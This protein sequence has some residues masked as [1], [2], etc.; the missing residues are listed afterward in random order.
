MIKVNEISWSDEV[1]DVGCTNG[2]YQPATLV[3]SDGTRMPIEVCRCG[4]GCSGTARIHHHDFEHDRDVFIG[5]LEFK[6][7]EDLEDYLYDN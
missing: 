6:D 2:N 5:D 3:L 7:L 1:R 4:C